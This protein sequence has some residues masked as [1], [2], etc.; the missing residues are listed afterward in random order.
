MARVGNMTLRI[1][2]TKSNISGFAAFVIDAFAMSRI[3]ALPP[4]N[5]PGVIQRP[6]AGPDRDDH[7]DRLTPLVADPKKCVALGIRIRPCEYQER[8]E[9]ETLADNRLHDPP[10]RD[11]R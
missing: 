10:P 4:A 6:K 11:Q 9:P 8:K 7:I 3:D 2:K 1:S 5:L